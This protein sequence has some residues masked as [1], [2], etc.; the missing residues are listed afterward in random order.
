M[1]KE[2]TTIEPSRFKQPKLRT[3][4]N[5]RVVRHA[6]LK[7]LLKNNW[8]V[9]DVLSEEDAAFINTAWHTL[10]LNR[11][12]EE[13]DLIHADPKST[14]NTLDSALQQFAEGYRW[15]PRPA[16][17]PTDRELLTDE[18]KELIAYA[19]PVYNRKVGGTGMARK[20]YE[21][22]LREF[23]LANKS[24]LLPAMNAEKASMA[25]LTEAL[26]RVRT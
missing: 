26:G 14:Y 21:D 8:N 13:S 24:I 4:D 3:A 20:D 22:Q 17:P 11:F 25:E 15:T 10:I 5:E 1:A 7:F 12:G 6:G 19:R 23:V 16:S 18:D 9:G 2:K